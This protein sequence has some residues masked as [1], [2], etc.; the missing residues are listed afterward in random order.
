MTEEVIRRA[1]KDATDLAGEQDMA[2][3]MWYEAWSKL[4]PGGF[5]Q[6]LDESPWQSP[7]LQSDPKVQP[8]LDPRQARSLLMSPENGV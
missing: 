3:V 6:L 2:Q 7:R 1:N 4:Q 8:T 5:L